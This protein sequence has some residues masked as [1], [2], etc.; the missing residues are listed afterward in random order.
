MLTRLAR[1][2]CRILTREKDLIKPFEL[3][4]LGNI[5]PDTADM[6]K[7]LIPSCVSL[8]G[9]P[10]VLARLKLSLTRARA[11][12]GR[13]HRLSRLD[14]EKLQGLLDELAVTRRAERE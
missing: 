4:Q 5:M 12:A 11:L 10:F 1:T 13:P 14:D 6:A 7:S 8:R 3:A 2:P 9:T